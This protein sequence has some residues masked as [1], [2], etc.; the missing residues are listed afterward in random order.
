[1]VWSGGS[2]LVFASISCFWLCVF[3]YALVVSLLAPLPGGESECLLNYR[4][5]KTMLPLVAPSVSLFCL[6]EVLNLFQQT[7][8]VCRR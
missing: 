5:K 2:S 8:I 1:M 4:Q 6:Y 7:F 3:D